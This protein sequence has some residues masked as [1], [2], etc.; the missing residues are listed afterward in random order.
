VGAE[1]GQTVLVDILDA[2]LK[3]V[4]DHLHPR[5]LVDIHARRAP[6][7]LTALL[8]AV[9]LAPAVGLG[10]A[11]HVVIVVG[12]APG[13]N[14]EGG[15]EEGCRAGAEL[16]DLGD[17]VGERGGVDEGLVVESALN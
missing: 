16:L 3:S 4:I 6:R 17:V 7:H 1:L 14:E 2:F 11:H 8:H 12:L 15:A 10:L 13:T 9:Q 5:T